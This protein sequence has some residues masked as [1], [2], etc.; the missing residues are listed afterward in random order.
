MFRLCLAMGLALALLAHPAGAHHRDRQREL[1]V[2]SVMDA[3]AKTWPSN[4]PQALSAFYQDHADVLNP[5]GRWARG[6]M[7][8]EKLFSDEHST[9]FK[10]SRMA[11]TID[12]MRFVDGDIVLVDS[13]ITI[14][15]MK[16][17]DGNALPPQSYHLV[18]VLHRKHDRWRMVASRPYLL[19]R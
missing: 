6:R 1:D 18:T 7:E 9:I 12:G 11:S 13:T 5:S 17:A 16:G 19:A 10:G 4:N 8:I 2:R 14:E 3:F 15:G